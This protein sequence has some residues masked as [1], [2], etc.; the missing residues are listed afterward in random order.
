VRGC[1]GWITG[2]TY[3]T[4]GPLLGGATQVVFEVRLLG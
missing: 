4:Y 1:S 2:H 3:I